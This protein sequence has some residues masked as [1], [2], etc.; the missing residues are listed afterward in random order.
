[1]T[2]LDKVRVAVMWCQEMPDARSRPPGV[3]VMRSMRCT[4]ERQRY[5]RLPCPTPSHPRLLDPRCRLSSVVCG[6]V[7][8]QRLF[9]ILLTFPFSSKVTSSRS[10]THRQ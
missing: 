10:M 2:R 8:C 9:R 4:D 5:R 6:P 3:S 7:I 1:M